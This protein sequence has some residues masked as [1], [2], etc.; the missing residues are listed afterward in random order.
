M[1]KEIAL[2][3]IYKYINISNIVFFFTKILVIFEFIKVEIN[4][5][6]LHQKTKKKGMFVSSFKQYLIAKK[7]TAE[8]L[9]SWKRSLT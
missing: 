1:Q 4:S 7:A 8:N 2:N 3:I 6:L 9:I 5:P